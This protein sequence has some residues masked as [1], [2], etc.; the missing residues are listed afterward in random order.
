MPGKTMLCETWLFGRPCFSAVVQ[1]W[2]THHHVALSK[3]GTKEGCRQDWRPQS[4][5]QRAAVL[6]LFL[7]VL[8]SVLVENGYPEN[9]QPWPGIRRESAE[10]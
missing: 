6:L 1:S 8:D 5:T 10:S 7:C 3:Q 2:A 4:F 9:S